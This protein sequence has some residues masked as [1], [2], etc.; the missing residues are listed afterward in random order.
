[1]YF[2]VLVFN[3]KKK[4]AFWGFVAKWTVYC[5]RNKESSSRFLVMIGVK[6]TSWRYEHILITLWLQLGKQQIL[7]EA[8]NT[9][10]VTHMWCWELKGQ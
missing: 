6:L 3:N 7:K 5:S 8:S 10:F 2:L 9:I 1:M 4:E